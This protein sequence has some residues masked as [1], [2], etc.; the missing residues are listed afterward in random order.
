M[1]IA[2]VDDEKLF[3]SEIETVIRKELF[4]DDVSCILY[5][6]GE[7][8]LSAV[9]NEVH[10]DAV[11]LDIGMKKTDGMTCARTLRQKNNPIPIV[12]VTSHVE[13]AM[14][15]YEVAAF[16]FLS[17]PI[18]VDRLRQVLEDLERALRKDGALILRKD[19]EDHLVPLK[20]IMYL[21]SANNDVRYVLR[22]G[23]LQVRGKL[24]DAL[25]EINEQEGYF[26][27]IHRCTVINLENVSRFTAGE[28]TMKNGEKLSVA[29][30]SQNMFRRVM[31][32]YVKRNGR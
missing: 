16:R 20:E 5:A 8:F 31:F 32:D 15:G 11:F 4:R 30:G 21:E 17:K 7:E 27:K 25:M 23:E 29:R 9:E 22:D 12:F 14:E 3:R 10:F 26:F 24:S 19:G 6:D 13:C 28:V 18:Q 2:I 1:R